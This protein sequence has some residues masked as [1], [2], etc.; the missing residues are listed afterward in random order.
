[1]ETS[2]AISIHQLRLRLGADEPN[3]A[4]LTRLGPAILPQLGQLVTDRS[5]Y[6]AANAASLAGMIGSEQAVAVLERAVQ[7]QSPIVRTAVAAALARVQGPKAAGLVSRLLTDRDKGVRKFAIRSA[8][9]KPNPA[10][11]S[12]ISALSKSDPQPHLRALASQAL[13]RI[14][15]V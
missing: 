7:N 9:A 5:T 1:M 3:Y 11:A 6:V 10:F 8:T 12:R 15:R 4:T 2:M 13:S 14:R